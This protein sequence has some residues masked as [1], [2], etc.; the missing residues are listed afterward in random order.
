MDVCKSDRSVVWML[1]ILFEDTLFKK[2][3]KGNFIV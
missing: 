3:F 1:I 2:P